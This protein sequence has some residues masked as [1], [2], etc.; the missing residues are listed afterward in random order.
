MAGYQLMKRRRHH[1]RH[2]LPKPALLTGELALDK[3]LQVGENLKRI[4]NGMRVYPVPFLPKIQTEIHE[5]ARGPWHAHL[6]AAL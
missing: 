1:L 4:R 5:N 3:V 6:R 2:P